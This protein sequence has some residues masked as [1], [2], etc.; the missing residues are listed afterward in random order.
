MRLFV[1]GMALSVLAAS[2]ALAQSRG[3][4]TGYHDA[5]QSPYHTYGAISPFGSSSLDLRNPEHVSAA[6][7]AA[8]R[9]CSAQ[10]QKYTEYTWGDM[11]FQQ[12]RS[13]M[14]Q[15]GQPE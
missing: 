8:T 11:E 5:L 14:A 9:A 12:Y 1:V 6:R 4:D 7:A 3:R 10:A 15:H 2:P 13:C